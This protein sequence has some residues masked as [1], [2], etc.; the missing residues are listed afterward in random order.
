MAEGLFFIHYCRKLST[1][2]SWTRLA[3]HVALDMVVVVED[4]SESAPVCGP[5]LIQYTCTLCNM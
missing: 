3:V 2:D 1:H 4:M 5:L